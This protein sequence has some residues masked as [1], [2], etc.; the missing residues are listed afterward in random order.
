MTDKISIYNDYFVY[1]EH[2]KKLVMTEIN[3]N[4]IK[5]YIDFDKDINN[6]KINN[7]NIVVY[8]EQRCYIYDIDS[9]TLINSIDGNNIILY[10]ISCKITWLKSSN[11][12]NIYRKENINVLEVHRS[13]IKNVKFSKDGNYMATVS[14][15]GSVIKIWNIYIQIY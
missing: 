15:N 2:K 6:T 9:L 1:V 7:Y 12:I 8:I 11:K 14:N 4:K 3:N 13:M 5:G 10:N